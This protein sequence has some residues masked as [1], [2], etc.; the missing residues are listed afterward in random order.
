[1]KLML[2]S[3]LAALAVA[4]LLSLTSVAQ[5]D[6]TNN[7]TNRDM[8]KS[9]TSGAPLH[10]HDKMEKSSGSGSLS[11]ADQ[12]FVKKAAEG[13]MAEVELGNL[14]KDKASSSEV[15]QFAQRMVD[16]H[17]KANEQLKSIASEKGVTLPTSLD[18]KDE[19]T[20]DRL[21]KLSG[22][23]FDRAYMNDMVKDHTKDVSEFKKES[24]AAK[25]PDIKSFASQTL[26]TLEDHL[27][28]ARQIAPKANK[29]TASR[30]TSGQ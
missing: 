19:A 6:T 7:S 2:R 13:G 21:S 18:A 4:L 16:D 28:E 10:H 24:T 25:D 26:P 8:H 22:D 29:E 23:Q 14:A 27:K 5:N 9:D 11:S 17:T 15:K 12:T 3:F 20:K 1:M 30:K